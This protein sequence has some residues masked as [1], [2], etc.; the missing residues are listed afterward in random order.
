MPAVLC[1]E[2]PSGA[3]PRDI[4]WTV[5]GEARLAYLTLISSLLSMLYT[6]M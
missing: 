4:M 6:Y 1:L 5:R 2:R 3:L